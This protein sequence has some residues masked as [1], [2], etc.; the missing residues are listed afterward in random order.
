MNTVEVKKMYGHDSIRPTIIYINGSKAEKKSEEQKSE[1]RKVNVG[2]NTVSAFKTPTDVKRVSDWLI[3]HKKYLHKFLFDLELVLGRRCGDI[4]NTKWSA[5]FNLDGSYKEFWTPSERIMEETDGNERTLKGEQK[6]GKYIPIPIGKTIKHSITEYCRNTGCDPAK[7][8]YNNLISLQLT[9]NY[10]NRP[11]SYTGFLKPLKRAAKECGITYKVATHSMR[12]TFGK[13]IIETNPDDP[14][15]KAI[16]QDLFGHSSDRIT[17]RYIGL[18]TER[19]NEA[20]SRVDEMFYETFVEGT[21]YV[22]PETKY[23]MSL[24]TS[25]LRELL[26]LAYTEGTKAQKEDDWEQHMERVNAIFEM[27]E[28][29]RI[30]VRG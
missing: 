5:F 26:T 11:I 23:I 18:D 12:K 25:D 13:S 4:L 1:K 30:G 16:A 9:G 17:N 6:T 14:N 19:K 28:E 15:A 21:E 8:D 29:L 27:A 10:K 20:V 3:E 7:N 2:I 24:K 22:S